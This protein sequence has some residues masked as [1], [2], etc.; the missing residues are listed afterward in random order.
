MYQDGTGV[1]QD[2]AEAAR[3]YEMA[4]WQGMAKAQNNLGI[5]YVLGKGVETDRVLA[6]VWFALAEKAGEVAAISNRERV[7]IQ[8]SAPQMA[9]AQRMTAAWKATAIPEPPP[10][11][12]EDADPE[13]MARPR[14]DLEN[15]LAAP[16]VPAA[17]IVP[18]APAAGNPPPPLLI[19]PAP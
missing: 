14:V 16:A 11:V 4:A 18:A 1:T 19:I 15:P 5:L 10:E 6:H 7:A 2:L 9:E 3:L 13:P 12:D 8:L 17:P